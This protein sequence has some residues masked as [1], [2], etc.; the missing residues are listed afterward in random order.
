M[1]WQKRPMEDTEP[2]VQRLFHGL[3]LERDI[4]LQSLASAGLCVL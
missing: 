4:G 2:R 1:A 3:Y